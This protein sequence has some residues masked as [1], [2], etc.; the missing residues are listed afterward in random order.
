MGDELALG[1]PPR[2]IL[3]GV[4]DRIEAFALQETVQFARTQGLRPLEEVT[5][6]KTLV[7]R[8]MV[9]T[10]QAPDITC[11]DALLGRLAVGEHE[12]KEGCA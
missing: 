10:E 12:P 4:H 5:A 8:G 9:S 1:Q 3:G 2:W 6:A 11:C 7:I